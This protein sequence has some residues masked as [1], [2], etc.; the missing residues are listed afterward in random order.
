MST[1][2]I[3]GPVP[4]YSNVNIAPQ[5]YQPNAFFIS[6]IALGI[7]TIVTTTVNNNYVIGQQARLII[8]PASGCRQLNGQQGV[9]LS[10]PA[11]NQIEL[12]I[13]SSQNVDPFVT[14]VDPQQPQILAIGD[15]N[16]G[17]TNVNGPNVI[18]YVSGAFI[19]IS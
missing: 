18:T 15:I 4:P 6:A 17:Q 19:N 5:N 12:I 7:T 11:P 2:A 14:S 8:P 13:N 10:L 9:V 3:Q 16:N 1:P